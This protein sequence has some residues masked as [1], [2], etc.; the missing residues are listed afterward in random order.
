MKYKELQLEEQRKETRVPAKRKERADGAYTEAT[1]N[2]RR[3]PKATAT[4]TNDAHAADDEYYATTATTASAF[5][6]KTG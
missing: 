1:S 6:F 3:K 5:H 4:T 2:A